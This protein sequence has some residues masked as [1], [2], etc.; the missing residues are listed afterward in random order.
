MRIASL[1]RGARVILDRRPVYARRELLRLELLVRAGRSARLDRPVDVRIGSRRVHIGRHSP[2]VDYV[3]LYGVVIDEI[4]AMNF[5]G[6]LVLDIGAHKGYFGAYALAMGASGVISY[7]P[8]S[9]N[10]ACL[11][12]AAAGEPRW[13]VHQQAVGAAEGV[14]T[15][16]ISAA[17]WGHS[18]TADSST[19]ATESIDVAALSSVLRVDAHPARRVIAKVNVE[20]AAG[21]M[22][23]GTSPDELRVLDEVWIDHEP[24]DVV[25]IEV[26]IDHLRDAGLRHD[27]V[28]LNRHH[29]RR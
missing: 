3:T 8:A 26:I 24:S 14:A 23:M 17:S 6:A 29:F 18:L 10:F 2:Y 20:G 12:L 13:T 22:L 15:L 28:S 5:A 19:V 16:H 7:E 4:F 21:Q 9:E 25:P 27:R 11:D 1:K